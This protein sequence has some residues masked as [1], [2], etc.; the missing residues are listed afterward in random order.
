MAGGSLLLVVQ[1]DNASA[2]EPR[3]HNPWWSVS[4]AIGG[5]CLLL[6]GSGKFPSIAASMHPRRPARLRA[7]GAGCSQRAGEA[8]DRMS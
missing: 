1:R 7:G 2:S 8:H 4:G 3:A 6:G 5:G